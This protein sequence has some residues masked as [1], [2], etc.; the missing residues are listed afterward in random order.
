MEDEIDFIVESLID[1]AYVDVELQC[2]WYQIITLR[3]KT[4]WVEN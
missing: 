3:G 1:R 2:K 4:K